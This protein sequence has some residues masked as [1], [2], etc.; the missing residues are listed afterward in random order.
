MGAEGQG[1]FAELRGLLAAR[2][3]SLAALDVS[4]PAETAEPVKEASVVVPLFIEGG[5][6]HFLLT[7]RVAALRRHAGEISFPGGVLDPSDTSALTTALREY[8][9]EMGAPASELDILGPL[10]VSATLTG[11]RIA[12]FVG[13]LSARPKLSPNAE[14]VQDIVD[15]RWAELLAP[16][17]HRVEVWEVSGRAREVHF[18][19]VGRHVIWGATARIIRNFFE[20]A[21]G[22]SAFRR[23]VAT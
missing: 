5:E 2:A 11:Y 14:E 6:P 21:Q 18:Y 1:L 8:E 10:E 4:S 9:E 13:A 7:H 16:G 12:P 17:V 22:L 15:V 20:V 19:T 3:G 23:F